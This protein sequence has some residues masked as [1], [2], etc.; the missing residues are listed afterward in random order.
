MFVVYVVGE[1]YGN[2]LEMLKLFYKVVREGN[3]DVYVVYLE[4]F[5][6]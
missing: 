6:S 2:N 1:Y 5:V 3:R 4:Y